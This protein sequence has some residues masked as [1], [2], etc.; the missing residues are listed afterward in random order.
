MR[1]ITQTSLCHEGM[2]VT[3]EIVRDHDILGPQGIDSLG[4][5]DI[6]DLPLDPFL[7]PRFDCDELPIT[8]KHIHDL[9]FV[10]SF[11]KISTCQWWT[12]KRVPAA[13]SKFH[14]PLRNI[15]G[16]QDEFQIGPCGPYPPCYGISLRAGAAAEHC[17]LQWI[18]LGVL[19]YQASD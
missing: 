4:L 8:V 9:H 15:H 18:S 1:D 11:E 10:H 3:K 13:L 16:V 14:R 5:C 2:H 6:A 7:Y 19:V 12:N 17:N